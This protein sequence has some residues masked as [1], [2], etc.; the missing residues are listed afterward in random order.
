MLDSPQPYSSR[1]SIKASRAV[2]WLC[3]A[4]IAAFVTWA[5]NV[6]VDQISRAQ[7]IVIPLSLI[8]I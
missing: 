5:A 2:I 6:E 8:H 3:L 4:F 1:T 7:G